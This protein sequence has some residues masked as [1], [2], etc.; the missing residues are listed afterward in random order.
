MLQTYLEVR[1]HLESSNSVL[2]RLHSFSGI[3]NLSLEEYSVHVVAGVLKLFFRQLAPP[4]IAADFYMDF[5][6]TAGQF[7]WNLHV[8]Y[9]VWSPFYCRSVAHAILR[10]LEK[11]LLVECL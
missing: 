2:N 5:I 3:D 6:R 9:V 10:I 8:T 1:Q 11:V 7:S 4:I